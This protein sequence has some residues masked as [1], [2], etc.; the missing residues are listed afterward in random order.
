MNELIRKNDTTNYINSIFSYFSKFPSSN[1]YLI[2]NLSQSVAD[3]T[4]DT[5]YLKKSLE[6]AE[7]SYLFMQDEKCYLNAADIAIKLNNYKKAYAILLEGQE[8]GMKEKR[9]FYKINELII[10]LKQKI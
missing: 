6:I 5:V 7:R 10:Q 9:K 8:Y 4:T 3:L 2:T 1:G